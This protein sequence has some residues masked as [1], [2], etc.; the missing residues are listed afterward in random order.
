M[1]KGIALSDSRSATR[2]GDKFN[3][4]MRALF[5]LSLLELFMGGGGRLM[6]VGS[7]SLRMVLL[8]ACLAAT[9]VA[10]LFPRRRSDGVL[11]AML[12]V[13]IYLL[14]H[15]GALVVG[16]IQS[17]D[18]SQLPIEFQ[19]SLYWLAAPFFAL[20]IQSEDDVRRYAR[21]AQGAG[22]ALA[23][24]YL[25][26]LVGLISGVLS[27]GLIRAVLGRG[28]EI[29]FRSGEFFVYKGFAYLGISIALLVALRDK[30][31]APLATLVAIAIML[32]FTRG[33]I[34]STSIG[35]LLMLCVQRR[36]RLA[37]PVIL[38]V[39][40]AAVF[41][42]IYLPSVDPSAMGSRDQSTNQRIQDMS[43]MFY[44]ARA[45]TFLVGEGYGSMI[46]NRSNIENTFLWALW[47]LGSI[48]LIFWMIPLCLCIYY[49]NKIPN[50]RSNP[51]A[52]AYLFGTVVVYVQTSTNPLL[53]NP[54]GL[55]FVMLAIF[56]LRILSRSKENT[57]VS[58]RMT[59]D[60]GQLIKADD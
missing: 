23:C 3:T 51:L 49:Y 58:G 24:A 54:I 19:Q 47:K 59:A 43:Y 7:V 12:L 40:T 30:Y 1:L 56:S 36:W 29:S 52:N 45:S 55:S 18:P 10:I 13:L 28:G 26:I 42:L 6:A 37:V 34:L 21:L 22:V 9:A 50:S 4:M 60:T 16:A 48:G 46:D 15:V 53:N 31:W 32:T 25:V 39:A 8:A 38:L 14:V 27:L 17:D 44:H 33:F 5:T 35:V 20:M 2:P 11:L 57:A 41:V